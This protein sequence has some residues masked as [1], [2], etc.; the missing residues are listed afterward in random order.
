MLLWR[1]V[2]TMLFVDQI[3]F[4]ST[5]YIAMIIPLYLLIPFLV[6]LRWRVS[7]RMAAWP[8][9]LMALV[10][11][12]IPSVNELLSLSG[13]SYQIVFAPIDF[14]VLRGWMTGYIL[15]VCVGH[16][17][18]R[19][20]LGKLSTFLVAACCAVSF[21]GTC[22]IQ[23][24]GYSRPQNYL[25]GYHFIG[26]VIC[27][28]LTFELIRRGAHLVRGLS[29][30]VTY[31]SQISFGIY[32]VHILIMSA[33]RWYLDLSAWPRYLQLACYEIVSFGGSVIII[34]LLSRIPA[35]KKYLFR[36]KDGKT[37][38]RGSAADGSA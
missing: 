26:I 12:L 13:N 33:M 22:G 16:W 1:M 28:A 11:T 23:L 6:I 10:Y 17:I 36:I 29:R 15:Y 9:G 18:S 24:Y 27:G 2:K 5:W 37:G 25:A 7:A 20:G 19:G 35:L 8:L 34:A 30:P 4:D 31:L 38:K 3:T 21:F 14:N 32:F